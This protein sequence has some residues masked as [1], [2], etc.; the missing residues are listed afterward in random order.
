[1]FGFYLESDKIECYKGIVRGMY[2]NRTYNSIV[3]LK[4]GVRYEKMYLIYCYSA[5]KV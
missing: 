2:F 3:L 4:N 1:M 5:K